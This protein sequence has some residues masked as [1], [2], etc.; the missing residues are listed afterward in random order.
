MG[1]MS[2]KKKLSM[3]LSSKTLSDE[4]LQYIKF[5]T[6]FDEKAIRDYHKIFMKDCP[7]GYLEPSTFKA[8]Y[9]LNTSGG[10]AEQFCE[11][12]FRTFDT[13]RSGY[14]GFKEFVLAINV[15]HSGSPEEKL[16]WT[17]HM[18]DVDGNGVVDFEEMVTIM[19]AMFNMSGGEAEAFKNA[20]PKDL[21][22]KIFNKMDFNNDGSLTKEE[23]VKGCMEDP[24]LKK[25][26][27]AKGKE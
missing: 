19:E 25:M 21:A 14:I 9:N 8:N 13:D 17:F 23:F 10:N 24:E 5:H 16:K 6:S 18:Y 3:S 4:E 27:F 2:F 12:I 15:T 11:H 20:K 22:R 7:R 1:K 26:L